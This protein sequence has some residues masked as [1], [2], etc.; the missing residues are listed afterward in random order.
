MAGK[1]KLDEVAG[2]DA[3]LMLMLPGGTPTKAGPWHGV[4]TEVNDR[5]VRSDLAGDPDVKRGRIGRRVGGAR[6][7]LEMSFKR[8]RHKWSGRLIVLADRRRDTHAAEQLGVKEI[9]SLR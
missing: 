6:R 4:T 2:M 1:T 8:R 3:E 7:P 5:H 9:Q